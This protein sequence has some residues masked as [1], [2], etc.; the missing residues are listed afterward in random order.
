MP[1]LPQVLH[2]AALRSAS[3][4]VVESGKAPTLRTDDGSVTVGEVIAASDLFDAL[5]RVLSPEQQAELAVGNVVEFHLD[6]EGGRWTLV[7][8]PTVDGIVVRGRLQDGDPSAEVGVP[9]ELPPLEPFE[10]KPAAA[11]P[12]ARRSRQ[13]RWDLAIGVEPEPDAPWAGGSTPTPP[14]AEDDGASRPFVPR[15]PRPIDFELRPPTGH[16]AR[17]DDATTAADL[18][19]LIT[20]GLDDP[21]DAPDHDGAATGSDAGAFPPLQAS[22]EATPQPARADLPTRRTGAHIA[23]SP[24]IVST[25]SAPRLD[26]ENAARLA[27][28]LGP[29]TLCLSGLR[30]VGTALGAAFEP[31]PVVVIDDPAPVDA[32]SISSQASAIYVI[33]VEDPSRWLG[34]VLRRLEEGARVIVETHALTAAGA[35]RTLLGVD[36]SPRA[37]AWLGAH[38]RRWLA[39]RDGRWTLEDA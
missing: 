33:R 29:G 37:D 30:G 12:R 19:E 20:P 3:E 8:E 1:S 15:R 38:P 6:V 22:H 28:D 9:L 2:E 26:P 23:A 14:R 32:R 25:A 10:P 36:A 31:V 11:A 13:T 7:T 4:V 21:D 18:P 35:V 17:L 5:G 27:A 34:F 16:Y 24:P 39:V